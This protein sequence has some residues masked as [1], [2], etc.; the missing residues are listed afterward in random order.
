[1]AEGDRTFTQEEVDA[2]IEKRLGRQKADFE[3]EKKELER[4]HGETIEEYEERIKNANL[5]AEEKH[6]KELEKIQKDLDA[7]NAELSTIKTNEIKRNM[8]AK[9]KLSEKFLS[10]VSGTTEEEIETSVKEFQEAIGE[11]MKSQA[12]GV[13]N[14]MTGGSNGGKGITKEQFSKMSYDEK[15]ELFNTDRA[16][17]DALSK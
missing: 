12:G 16:T 11:F 1:M 10:R 2:I 17:Y 5:T 15:V 8:L 13:P 4:K 7:K 9:Y 14:S 6:K 3:K